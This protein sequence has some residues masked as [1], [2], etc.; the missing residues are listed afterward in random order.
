GLKCSSV[1]DNNKLHLL[2]ISHHQCRLQDCVNSLSNSHIP[3]ESDRRFS[4]K[5][6]K[7]LWQR[8][9]VLRR[10]FRRPI[11]DILKRAPVTK[12]IEVFLK[13]GGLNHDEIQLRINPANY[14]ADHFVDKT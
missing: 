6:L 11:R 9:S 8:I 2:I 4:W 1:P 13:G 7:P 3:S 5:I 14:P 12:L 10:Q